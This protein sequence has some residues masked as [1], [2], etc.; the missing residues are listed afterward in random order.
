MSSAKQELFDRLMY[1]NSAIGLPDLV[2]QGI[3]IS[4][5]NGRANLLRKGLGIVAFNIL[6]DFI[7]NRSFEALAAIS[8]SRVAFSLL[9]DT[10]REASTIGA[11]SAL[12]FRAKLEKK[13]G[14]DFYLLIQEEALKI[15]STKNPVFELSKFSLVSTGSNIGP[16]EVTELL[17]A[18]GI[19][20]GWNTMK[21]VSDAIGGGIPDLGQCYRNSAERRHSAAHSASF[22][23]AYQWLAGIKNEI[24]AIAASLDILLSA[25]CRQIHAEPA[26]PIKSHDISKALNY[27]WLEED[28]SSRFR[29]TTTTGGKAR[30]IWSSLSDAVTALQ[31]LAAPRNEFLIVRD[32]SKRISDWH[33]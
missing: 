22:Q 14:K 30:K 32:S 25:R 24:I 33:S 29:E 19:D 1:L 5:H 26:K 7:K 20:G 28:A 16:Q 3:A 13:D 10:L 18:F 2:D 27:R 9:T 8:T 21:V 4:E 31:P 23:Y 12:A 11:L 15:H 17:S 6:E